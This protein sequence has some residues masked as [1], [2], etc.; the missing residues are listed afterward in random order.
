MFRIEWVGLWGTVEQGCVNI[1]GHR[2]KI[3]LSIIK[4]FWSHCRCDV[5]IFLLVRI[6]AAFL[7][8]VLQPFNNRQWVHNCN[9]KWVLLIHIHIFGKL[10]FLWFDWCKIQPQQQVQS[11]PLPRTN[12]QTITKCMLLIWSLIVMYQSI[13]FRPKQS[14]YIGKGTQ[15]PN[16]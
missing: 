5:I 11:E 4:L 7:L 2:S 10:S 14:C 13:I 9:F 12:K 15:C 6:L 3:L 16:Q 1:Y 8:A